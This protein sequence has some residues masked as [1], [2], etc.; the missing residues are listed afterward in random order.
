MKYIAEENRKK[1]DLHGMTKEEAKYILEEEI[2][3]AEEHIEMI[4]AVHGY[5]L[6]ST[7]LNM[8]R[9][10]LHNDRIKKIESTE[11]PAI[12]FIYL[13]KKMPNLRKEQYNRKKKH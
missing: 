11:N 10:E 9:T 13:E 5:S 2:E 6:G 7:L 12:T 4:I 1:I 3:L 8:V